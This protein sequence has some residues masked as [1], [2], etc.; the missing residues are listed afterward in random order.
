MKTATYKTEGEVVIAMND[1]RKMYKMSVEI[2]GVITV[3]LIAI[4]PNSLSM[5]PQGMMNH[6]EKIN[7]SLN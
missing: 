5:F 4:T 7:I 2:G 3:K 6:F 1:I